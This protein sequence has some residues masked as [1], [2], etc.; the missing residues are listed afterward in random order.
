MDACG[1]CYCNGCDANSVMHVPNLC[2]FIYGVFTET[3][4]LDEEVGLLL[5]QVE[6]ETGLTVCGSTGR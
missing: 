4:V 1:C 3:G 2:S 6:S 5:K